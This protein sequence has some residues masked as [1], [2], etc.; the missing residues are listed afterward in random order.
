MSG[1]DRLT[2]EKKAEPSASAESTQPNGAVV[3]APS[4]QW[5]LVDPTGATRSFA[6]LQ[7]LVS[8]LPSTSMAPR[9]G[10]ALLDLTPLPR[11]D[12]PPTYDLVTPKIPR[13]SS[14]APGAMPPAIDARAEELS[15]E[16]LAQEDDEDDDDDDADEDD[17]EDDDEDRDPDEMVSLSDMTVVSLLA[18]PAPAAPRAGTLRTLPPTPR[19]SAPPPPTIDVGSAR[20]VT[21]HGSSTDESRGSKRSWF[22]TA[23]MVTVAVGTAAYLVL[24]PPPPGE[25]WSATT[26]APMPMTEPRTAT[27]SEEA[28]PSPTESSSAPASASAPAASGDKPHGEGV[29]SL[30]DMLVRASTARRGGDNARAKELL[31][32]ALTLSPGNA[33]AY[34]G[35]GEVARA[36][37]NMD[38]ARSN[39]E[40]ALQSSP[41]YYPALMGL[42]DTLWD[43]GDRDGARRTYR[44]VVDT[45]TSPPER[46]KER[47]GGGTSPAGTEAPAPSVNAERKTASP[48]PSQSVD[49]TPAQKTNDAP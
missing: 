27:S 47:A 17:I 31:T 4:G 39:F 36:E 35:L 37:G 1:G 25:T 20:P 28:L 24:R 5:T 41:Q 45:A 9:S 23:A 32:R 8:A 22:L 43:L 40:R 42:G 12:A 46:A 48:D 44:V 49:Q 16:E 18:A 33:E 19:P 10:S 3:H 7:D 38:A 30:S 29:L 6:T 26:V 15:S 2:E 21:T 13:V 14:F 11:S 34:S